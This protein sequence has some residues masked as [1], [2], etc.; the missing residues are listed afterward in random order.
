MVNDF[1]RPL[2]VPSGVAGMASAPIG[3][4]KAVF[5]FPATPFH[6]E[7]EMR[8]ELVR[9]EVSANGELAGEGSASLIGQGRLD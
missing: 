1:D 4:A 2:I 9:G 8:I 7:Y 6:L 3:C 5:S